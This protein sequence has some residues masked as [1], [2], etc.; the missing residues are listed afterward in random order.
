MLLTSAITLSGGLIVFLLG[1]L[2]IRLMLDPAVEMRRIL[3]RTERALVFYANVYSDPNLI[4]EDLVTKASESIRQL[5]SELSAQ[6]HTTIQ[7]S[8]V[9]AFMSLPSAN[10]I[11]VA[12][13]ELIGL[14]NMTTPG[15]SEKVD[16]CAGSGAFSAQ[17]QSAV[18][19][20]RQYLRLSVK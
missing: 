20:I 18:G 17:I 5:A 3:W 2:F 6:C 19:L 12:R 13:K 8:T 10:D 9:A 14:S 15:E 4:K 11:D 7:Y 1:Q 16:H